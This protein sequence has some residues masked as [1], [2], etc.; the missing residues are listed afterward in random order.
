MPRF[1]YRAL[2]QTGGEVSGELVATDERAAATQLQ[3]IGSLPI[4]IA[5]AAARSAGMIDLKTDGLRKALA[6]V[7][8]LE[9]VLRVTGDA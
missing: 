7:T 6:G 8:S 1:R 2:R 3:A 9:E 5:P 4:E